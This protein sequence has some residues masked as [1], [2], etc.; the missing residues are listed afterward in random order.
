MAKRLD[1]DK[2]RREKRG[3]DL[4][5][6]PIDKVAHEQAVSRFLK[7]AKRKKSIKEVV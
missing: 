7:L 4:S 2:V 3:A 1:W 5:A 6:K